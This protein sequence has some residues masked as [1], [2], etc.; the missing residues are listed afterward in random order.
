M[1]IATWN[2]NSI[3]MRLEHLLTWLEQTAVDVVC[4]QETK[5]L[6]AQFPRAELEAK[7]YH[8]YYFGQK[9]YN[10]VA[11]LSRK[12]IKSIF[13]GFGGILGTQ[14]DPQWDEQ[15]RVIGAMYNDL[16]II[17]LY[18]PNGSSINSEK[19]HYKL[20]WLG[21][22][23]QYLNQV[24]KMTNRVH[25][26]GDFNIAPDSRDIHESFDGSEHIMASIEERQALQSLLSSGFIDAFRYFN[27]DPGHFTWWDYRAG[28]FRR[29]LGWRIDHHYVSKA[30]VPSILTCE[31]DRLP[32]TWTKPSDH[33]P[34]ILE[35]ES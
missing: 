18:V 3:R 29:N 14:V 8:C 23:S 34:V 13:Y 22:L 9:S 15:K 31:I 24:L 25:F 30:L 35:L 20:Q 4:L 32:R 19:Y 27:A 1:K 5:V 12:E 10:G 7:G 16:M 26:C 11:L 28:S 21:I 2:V 6:D 17:N 33:T